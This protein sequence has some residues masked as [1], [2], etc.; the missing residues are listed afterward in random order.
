MMRLF[1]LSL[2][3]SRFHFMHGCITFKILPVVGNVY[4]RY[5]HTALHYDNGVMFMCDKKLLSTNFD[6]KLFHQ[7]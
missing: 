5:F 1:L 6:R 7:P 3:L 2:S 4:L